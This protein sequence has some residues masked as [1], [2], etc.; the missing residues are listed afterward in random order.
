MQMIYTTKEQTLPTTEKGNYSAW[1]TQNTDT[2][3]APRP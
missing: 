3:M 2:A 1:L